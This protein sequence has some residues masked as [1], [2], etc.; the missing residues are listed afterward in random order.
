MTSSPVSPAG[1]AISVIVPVFNKLPFLRPTLDSIPLCDVCPAFD[2]S[3]RF[4]GVM[5]VRMSSRMF[6]SYADTW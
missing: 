3:R 2:A 4:A 1:P 6:M 5:N